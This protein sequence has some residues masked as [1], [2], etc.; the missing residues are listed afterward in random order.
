MNDKLDPKSAITEAIECLESEGKKAT[1]ESIREVTGLA[2][3][4][5]SKY[6]KDIRIERLNPMDIDPE[7]LAKQV[8]LLVRKQVSSAIC[9]QRDAYDLR[10]SSLQDSFDEIQKEFEKTTRAYLDKTSEVEKLASVNSKLS[11]VAESVNQQLSQLKSEHCEFTEKTKKEHQDEIK[12]LSQQIEEV[13]GKK[14]TAEQQ[15]K[16]LLSKETHL[17][18]Q[19]LNLQNKLQGLNEEV[20]LLVKGLAVKESELKSEKQSHLKATENLLETKQSL[21]EL[22]NEFKTL[23]Q[24]NKRL[25]AQFSGVNGKVSSQAAT[26]E[27]QHGQIALLK[28][29]FEQ[30]VSRPTKNQ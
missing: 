6:I 22:H 24:E 1:Y 26:I 27:S 20:T 25:Y 29:Q 11:G 28:S 7:D 18:E 23:E 12:K 30:L 21:S 17:N 15:L 2:K 8:N 14:A 5:I 9:Q 13:I 10:I 19:V 4:T 3:A 16:Y